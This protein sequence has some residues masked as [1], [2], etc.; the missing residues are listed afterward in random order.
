MNFFR[1][2][3]CPAMLIGVPLWLFSGVLPAMDMEAAKE[4]VPYYLKGPRP[5]ATGKVPPDP[6][7]EDK[8]QRTLESYHKSGNPLKHKKDTSNAKFDAEF[9]KLLQPPAPIVAAI[10]KQNAQLEEA[11]AKRERD[12]K[13]EAAKQDTDQKKR[14]VQFAMLLRKNLPGKGT[15]A[16]Y[17]S[18]NQQFQK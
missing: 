1:Q 18:Y 4:A 3:V 17:S 14:N 6:I 12:L 2:R 10:K 13:S 7:Q 15:S 9:K 16:D 8:L 11:H 5:L